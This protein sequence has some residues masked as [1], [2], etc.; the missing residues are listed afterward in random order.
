MKICYVSNLYPPFVLGGAEVYVR[1]IAEEFA[2]RGDRVIVI[3][4]SP[5]RRSYIEYI[6][7]VK[8][9]RIN[10]TN[11]YPM[12]THVNQPD[13][14]KPLWHT[15]DIW[16]PHSFR[17]IK[18]ILVKEKPDVVHVHNF[19]GLSLS[20]FDAVK[21][22]NLP[23]IF[24]AHD[25]SLICPRANLLNS[26]GEICCNPSILCKVYV[27]IQKH[28]VDGKPDLVTAPSQ[29]VIDKLKEN[30]LFEDVTAIKLPLGIKLNS[31]ERIEKD[32]DVIDILYAG[33]LSRHKGVHILIK[34]FKEIKHDN[35]RLHITGK[36]KDA[37]EFRKL[38]GSDPKIKFYD[39]VP[40]EKLR[41][42]YKMANIVVVPSIWYE[43][44]PVV[45]Y[46]SFRHQ[47]PVI[48]SRI[49]GIPEL[50]EEGENGFLFTPGSVEELKN[51]LED[52]INSPEKLQKLENRAFKSVK[53]YRMD[54]HIRKLEQL[55]EKVKGV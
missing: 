10:P 29:F 52:L 9:Y 37:E 13:Y 46:E 55:Y 4:T 1:N 22:L 24:T 51:I 20:V 48:G 31:N 25:Y 41:E 30:G 8:V 54:E 49:G 47:T 15:I 5:N 18:S 17:V 6:N 53:K 27:R 19:K 39:F 45:I 3:T 21:S 28:L 26:H 44:S 40:E 35:I 42:L 38:A 12:Y 36:G 34:A 11:L 50:V 7:N 33:N 14:L 43:N 32:Y 23:L 16:N 2:K